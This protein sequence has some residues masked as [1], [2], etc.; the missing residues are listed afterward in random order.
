MIH[1]TLIPEYQIVALATAATIAGSRSFSIGRVF[2]MASNG[3][4]LSRKPRE[5]TTENLYY[6][7]ARIGGCRPVLGSCRSPRN[8]AGT[9]FQHDRLRYPVSEPLPPFAKD[10]DQIDSS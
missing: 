10:K 5:H 4:G 3:L 9:N 7:H 2:F 8:L 6:P 1:T